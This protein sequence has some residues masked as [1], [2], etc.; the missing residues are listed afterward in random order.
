MQRNRSDGLRTPRRSAN[1][2]LDQY[3]IGDPAHFM[4]A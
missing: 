4:E 2:T 1:G 3:R